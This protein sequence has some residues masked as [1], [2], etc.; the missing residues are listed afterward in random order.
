MAPSAERALLLVAA[1]LA[2][3]PASAAAVRAAATQAAR[4]VRVEATLRAARTNECTFEPPPQEMVVEV[5]IHT[6]LG[7]RK[8]LRGPGGWLEIDRAQVARRHIHGGDEA[9]PAHAFRLVER[10]IRTAD[11]LLSG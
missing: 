11:E 1:V 5:T 2:M 10:R 6:T 3:L 7:R 8:Q 4:A 9:V